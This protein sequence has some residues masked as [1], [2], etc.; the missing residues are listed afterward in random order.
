MEGVNEGRDV[1]QVDFAANIKI[2]QHDETFA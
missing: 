1:N 2:P